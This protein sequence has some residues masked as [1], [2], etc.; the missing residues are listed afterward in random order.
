MG[1][2]IGI[3]V[4]C[5]VTSLLAAGLVGLWFALINLVENDWHK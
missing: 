5:V 3:A 2:W 1:V 4:A